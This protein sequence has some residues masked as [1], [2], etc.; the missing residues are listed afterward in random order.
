MVGGNS[1]ADS[2]CHGKPRRYERQQGYVS[3]LE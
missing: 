1:H 3:G 2:C